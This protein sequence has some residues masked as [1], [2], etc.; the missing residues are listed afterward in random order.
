MTVLQFPHKPTALETAEDLIRSTGGHPL[1]LASML[2][3]CLAMIENEY[4]T[5]EARRSTAETARR[6]EIEAAE[7]G[8]RF[9]PL[10][11]PTIEP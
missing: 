10:V 3:F 9:A 5:T 6:Q 4:A 2:P 1:R 7:L 8:L 11:W